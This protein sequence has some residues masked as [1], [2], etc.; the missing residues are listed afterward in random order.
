MERH[1]VHWKLLKTIS[2]LIKPIQILHEVH[3]SNQ[4]FNIQSINQSINQSFI[5]SINQSLNH[6]IIQSINRL[7][8]PR[9]FMQHTN[10]HLFSC[11]FTN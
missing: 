5:Q 9:R 4:S 1:E 3:S 10:L 11:Y 2:V 7:N 6:S 8:Q